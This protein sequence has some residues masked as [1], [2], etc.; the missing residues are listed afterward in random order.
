MK[1]ATTLLTILLL[2][3]SL[4]TPFANVFPEG[5]VIPKPLQQHS[6]TNI[7]SNGSHESRTNNYSIT[8]ASRSM[9]RINNGE[10]KSVTVVL[11]RQP[12]L[13]IMTDTF[14]TIINP[15][16]EV[17]NKIDA[18][19]LNLTSL[20]TKGYI[21]NNQTNIIISISSKTSPSK[22]AELITQENLAC[23]I[24]ETYTNQHTLNTQFLTAHTKYST[25]FELAKNPHIDYIWLNRKFQACLDQSV[26]II[27]DPTEWANIES[28]FNRQING[29]GIKIAIIDTGIDS[30][31]PDF[32]FPDNTSKIVATASFTGEPTTDG[33][34]HGTHCASISAGTGAASTGQYTGVASGAALLNVKVLDNTGEGLESWVISGI[35]WAVQNGASI[36]S[37][38]FGSDTPSSGTDPLSTTVNWATGQGTVCVIAAGNLGS[39][40]YTITSPGDASSAITVGASSKTDT[41]ASFSSRGPTTDYRIKPDLVAPGVHIAAARASG[42][43]M[44][45]PVSQY[46]TRASGTSMATPHVAGAAALLLDAHHYWSPTTVKAAL[47]NYAR[48]IG[49]NTLEQGSGRLDVCK[50]TTASIIGT[51]STSFGRIH[52]DTTYNQPISFQNLASTTIHITMNAETRL[53][54]NGALYNVA[55]LSPSSLDLTPGASRTIELQLDTS[56]DLTNGHFEGKITATFSTSNIRTLFFFCII[57]ELNVEVTDE[58]G[59][60]LNAAFIL[61]N[62]ATGETK[63][64]SGTKGQFT[65]PQGNY[66]IQ[67]MDIFW[68]SYSFLVHQKFS[69]G[70]DE[71][72]NLQLSLTSA[73]KLNV[74]STDTTG[75]P[76]HLV[77]KQFRTPYYSMAYFSEIGTF[78]N[79][80]LYLTN[81]CEYMAA[82]C[83]FGFAAFSQDDLQW[84]ETGILT[85]DVDAY[86]IGWDISQ[87]GLSPVPTALDY[88]DSD[89]A[90]FNIENMLP[91]STTTS[92]IWFN[93]IAG[94]WRSGLWSGYQIHPGIN[95]K[96][97]VLPYQ[98]RN[99][100]SA[101]WSE[102]EWSC[103]YEM[104]TYPGESAE[105]FV[106]DRHFDPIA[107]GETFTYNM[108]KTPLVPQTVYE[109]APYYGSGLCIPYYPLLVEKNLF[110]AKSDPQATKRVEILKDGS[111][112]YDEIQSWAQE[113]IDIGQF[114]DSHGYGVYSFI[115]KT[116]T[117][118]D[119]SSQNVAEY[120]IDYTSSS[121]DLIPPSITKIDCKPCFTDNEYQVK[122]Q[123]ADNHELSDVSLLYSMDDGPLVSST[124]NDLGEGFY[125]ANINIPLEVQK[126]SLTVEAA[127]RSG[128]SIQFSTEPAATRG[129]ETQIDATLSENRIS[130]KLTVVGGA[131]PQP[132]YLKVKSDGETMFTLTD[133]D[134]NFEFAVPQSMVFPVEIEMVSMGTLDG[135]ICVI[136][137]VQVHDVSITQLVPSK[138]VASGNVYIDVTVENQGSYTENLNVT[139]YAN[140]TVIAAPTVYDLPNGTSTI[141]TFAWN[142]TGFTYGHYTITA[143][144]TPVPGET[145]LADNTLTDGIVKLTIVGD[146]NGDSIVDIFDC[147]TIALAFGSIPDDSNWNPNADINNDSIVDIFDMVVVALHFGEIEA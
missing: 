141:L 41:I 137:M 63:T 73:H 75:S 120:V 121:T 135:S 38:S 147:V 127:D 88:A 25:L 37:M 11:G 18:N 114:L 84:T 72:K 115:V 80:Y 93:Q 131:F 106:V 30:S 83:Y 47:T 5:S 142:T 122:I 67:A 94:M 59:S 102:L 78:A 71:T 116:E 33:H 32:Y 105:Y 48:N 113:P 16:P 133:G 64:S 49:S 124:L 1:T 65:I 20:V 86:F 138:T 26:E 54:E 8:K 123:L 13:Q 52:L 99:P 145:D 89:L 125:S 55:S 19:L 146:V 2:I 98:Y 35:Q 50:S 107:K 132:V 57:S 100:S 103:M 126:I 14:S 119:C 22:I 96:I 9:I 104:S 46:Y 56:L 101:S 97:H 3:Y 110:L 76:L 117:S 62:T 43:T 28:S 139:V 69:I 31:H 87:F 81:I 68:T 6:E 143:Y 74:R 36:L 39:T 92:T 12:N 17:K 27:K 7:T 44:G 82:P 130:G 136:D 58:I 53:I 95:W 29:S 21:Q 60:K 51:S 91:K 129:H 90:T 61:I 85:S 10:N 24:Y 118:L 70:K 144:V 34:G 77:L 79:H 111:P 4:T 45:T 109:D 23:E 128:N 15:P 140:T 40:M 42:T 134:G 108:G 66:V 112:I